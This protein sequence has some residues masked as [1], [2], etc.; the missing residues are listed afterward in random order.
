MKSRGFVELLASPLILGLVL[1]GLFFLTFGGLGLVNTFTKP[2]GFDVVSGTVGGIAQPIMIVLA[3]F[4]LFRIALIL[5]D[6]LG[7]GKP[8]NTFSLV[9]L[10]LITGLLFYFGS[11]AGLTLAVGGEPETTLTETVVSSD[12]IIGLV[13]GSVISGFIDFFVFKKFFGRK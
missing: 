8:V 12:V 5:L 10:V 9:V 4:I 7:T 3:L 11:G 1:V 6:V 13:L 2:F